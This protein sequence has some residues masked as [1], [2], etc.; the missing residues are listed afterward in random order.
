MY[1]IHEYHAPQSVEEAYGL[2]TAHRRNAVLGG[3]LWLK[4]GRRRIKKGIDLKN[5]GLDFIR[6]IPE[7]VE[8][9]ASATLR[10]VET[11]PLLQELWGRYFSDALKDLVGVQF[12]NCASVGGAIY[13]RSGFSD[14][15]TAALAL[16]GRVELFKGGIKS[17]EEYCAHPPGRDIVMRIILPRAY[18]ACAYQRLAANAGDFPLLNAAVAREGEEWRLAVGARPQRGALCPRAAALLREDTGEAGIARAIAMAQGELHFGSNMRAS[19]A[20]RK[21]IAAVLLE[22]AIRRVLN[23]N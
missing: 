4:M 17:M 18:Q 1:T 10:Q 5:C 12:R 7:G 21:E 20:Y 11:S 16:N 15:L 8:I 23:G 22:K 13:A 14:L 2:L 3:C 9:G 19:A 6:A